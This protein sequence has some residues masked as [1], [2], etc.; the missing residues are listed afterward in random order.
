MQLDQ[1]IQCS[2]SFYR[3]SIIREKRR[4]TIFTGIKK[5]SQFTNRL[6][7]TFEETEM[8]GH[9]DYLVLMKRVCVF[10][11]DNERRKDRRESGR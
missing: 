9:V 8:S 5:Q 2:L 1:L 7:V 6:K 3:L 4:N 10:V 11:Y